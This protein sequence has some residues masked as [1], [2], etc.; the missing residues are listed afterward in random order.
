M[1]PAVT[2]YFAAILEAATRPSDGLFSC[3]NG[4]GCEAD[5]P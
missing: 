4:T 5:W 1:H 2:G 3:R